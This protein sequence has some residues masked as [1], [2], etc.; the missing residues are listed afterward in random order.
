MRLCG[1]VIDLVRLRL[2]YDTEDITAVGQV[3][4]MQEKPAFIVRIETIWSIRWVFSI[5]LL[6]GV[7]RVRYILYPVIILS[8]MPR[9]AL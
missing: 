6:F 8:N 1:Q 3:A 7:C 9:L 4:V 2:L 5:E